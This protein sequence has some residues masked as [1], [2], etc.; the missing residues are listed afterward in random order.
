MSS[1]KRAGGIKAVTTHIAENEA[2]IRSMMQELFILLRLSGSISDSADNILLD[3]LQEFEKYLEKATSDINSIYG[4]ADRLI[5]DS[6]ELDRVVVETIAKTRS[7]V[8]SVEATGSS[9][10]Y[11]Q[12]S[13]QEMVDL[14]SEVKEASL[15]VIKGVSNIEKIASQ[16]NL[17]ALNAAI[18]AAQAGAHGKGF[19]VVAEEVKKLANTSSS[20]TKDIVGLLENLEERMTMAETAMAAF[21]EKHE[22]VTEN[23][24]K[25]D[26]DIRFTLDSLT[27]VSESLQNVTGLVEAQSQ[28]TKE[29]IGHI[30]SA[31]KNV[32]RVIEESKK[33]D[34][35]T[36]EINSGA[37]KLNKV[38][39]SQFEN[40]MDLKKVVYS[41]T[42]FFKRKGLVIAH[43]DAFPPWVFVKE[44]VS[45]GISVDIFRLITERLGMKGLFVG[46]TWSSVFPMLTER[47]FDL[48][49]NAGWP[50]PYFDSFPVIA[51]EA[52][53]RFEPVIFKKE[54]APDEKI[55]L[56]DLQGKKVGVQRA[57][58]GAEL[59]KGAGIPV[60]EYD[61]DAFSFLDHF[62]G[63]TDYVVAERMVGARLN[64]QYFQNNIKVVSAPIEKME[65][66]CLAHEK[67]S[68]LI[69][70]INNEIIKMRSSSTIN[71]IK[72][73][74]LN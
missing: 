24:K 60:N 4:N 20:I 72:A 30:S 8:D 68:R 18:E 13:F 16:T 62:W 14:F 17:L 57:G 56:K 42:L 38:I 51:S 6:K 67:N 23:I 41:A 27:G 64:R 40:V 55:T 49:L 1:N 26:N 37:T 19:A 35:T 52:Y 29:V 9:M 59:L 54:A 58:L 5:D 65:V 2:K 73:V 50:N 32:D 36:E 61:N 21:Q 74:Y 43:D 7:I 25:E 63:K 31:A 11:M 47:R 53:V 22:E 69:A 28:S 70:K 46:A 10:N 12:G 33:V 44:G 66:V 48:I 3:Q 39:T 71:E 34:I 45:S 15:E